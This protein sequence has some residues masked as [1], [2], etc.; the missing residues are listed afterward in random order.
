ME[1]E[2]GDAVR[3]SEKHIYM[4]L[5]DEVRPISGAVEFI[6]ALTDLGHDVVLASSAKER[7]VDHYLD[8]LD[9]RDEVHA[10]TTSADVEATK[11]SP[12]LIKAALAKSEHD[13]AVMVG[14]STWDCVAAK[15]ASIPTIGVL[16]GG[17]AESELRDAGAA[18][19]FESVNDLKDEIHRNGSGVA[20]MVNTSGKRVNTK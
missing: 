20:W 12:D 3:E 14:D 13:D 4:E 9:V 19:V 5:I 10:W 7:E 1:R 6:E 17:F 15:R 18:Q 2:R 16:T 11:P 8:L